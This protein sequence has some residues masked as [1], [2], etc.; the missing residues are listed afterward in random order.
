M[1]VGWELKVEFLCLMD[2]YIYIDG[3]FLDDSTSTFS[4]ELHG[5]EKVCGWP[6]LLEA[7]GDL[8]GVPC[9]VPCCEYLWMQC[10]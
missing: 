7:N 3:T 8:W 9:A 2:V 5:S 6:Q 4:Q 10:F 1:F